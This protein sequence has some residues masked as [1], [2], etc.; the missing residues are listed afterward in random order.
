M[1][2]MDQPASTIFVGD[3]GTGDPSNASQ[4][5]GQGRLAVPWFVQAWYERNCSHVEPTR[6][7]PYRHHEGANYVFCDGHAKWMRWEEVYPGTDSGTCALTGFKR[8]YAACAK[9]HAMTAA[10]RAECLRRSQ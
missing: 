3:G 9:W 2:E 7:H 4:Q 8:T 6:E 1:A 10:E 5:T